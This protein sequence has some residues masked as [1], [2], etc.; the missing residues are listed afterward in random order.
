MSARSQMCI[1]RQHPVCGRPGR[2][3][4]LRLETVERSCEG[5]AEP[6][7]GLARHVHLEHLVG[8]LTIKCASQNEK[9]SFNLMPPELLVYSV[10]IHI[11][12]PQTNYAHPF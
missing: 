5:G 9:D 11:T 4:W 6:S 1:H 2:R 8:H 7:L 3:V 10:T 12:A